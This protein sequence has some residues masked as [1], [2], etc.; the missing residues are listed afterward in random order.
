MLIDNAYNILRK[1]RLMFCFLI[2]SL[3]MPVSTSAQEIPEK[4]VRIGSF[5][6]TYNTVNEKGERSGYG[7]EYLQN[8]GGYT[9]WN[10]EYV[11]S[12]WAD[13]F[14]Q[15]EN[16]EIDILG[17][18]SYT[19]E[20][21][22]M[23]LFSDMPMGEE[24]YYIYADASN[25][26]L[27]AAELGSF[28]GKK[29]GVLKDHTPEDVLDK[30]ETRYGLHTQH[31]NVSSV[32]EIQEKLANHEIDCFVSVEESRWGEAGLSPIT[33]IG[34]SDI[35]FAI[36][37]NHP[38]IKEALDSAMRRIRD[39]NPFYTDDLY[40]RYFSAQSSGFLSKEEKKNGWPGMVPSGLV[41]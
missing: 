41:I 8:I 11:S 2:L 3:M 39:D 29:I 37:K 38:E 16:N 20:R 5:E 33:N 35:Y 6:E 10:Y 24:K 18:I 30:W 17:G 7:Y 28:E 40:K 25:M 36:S 23:M 26:E 27:T 32:D 4:T 22:E 19:E 31:V 21:A 34:G 9:G 15:L 12:S 14:K 13:C 1:Y